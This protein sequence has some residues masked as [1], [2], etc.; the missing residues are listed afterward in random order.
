M[1]SG[2]ADKK[3]KER[4]DKMDRRRALSASAGDVS[5]AADR[6]GDGDGMMAA[7]SEPDLR[8]SQVSDMHINTLEVTRRTK[9]EIWN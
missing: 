9:Y 3:K 7:A 2:K 5:G 6:P 8:D 1:L 4:Q